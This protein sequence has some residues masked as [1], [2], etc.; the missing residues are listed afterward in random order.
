M[1]YTIYGLFIILNTSLVTDY[2]LL[3]TIEICLN[4]LYLQFWTAGE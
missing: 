2:Q 3:V 4:Q 1:I